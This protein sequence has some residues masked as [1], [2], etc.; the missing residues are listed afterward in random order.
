L[1]SVM[2]SGAYVLY[3]PPSIFLSMSD[4]AGA[5]LEPLRLHAVAA[6]ASNDAIRQARSAFPKLLTRSP[7]GHGDA[8]SSVL[9]SGALG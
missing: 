2:A 1:A 7:R 4:D 6:A 8:R 5:Q 3:A 9:R